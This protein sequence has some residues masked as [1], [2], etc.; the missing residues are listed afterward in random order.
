[1]RWRRP[2]ARTCWRQSADPPSTDARQEIARDAQGPISSGFHPDPTICRVVED[3][4]LANSS[5]DYVP[6][7]PLGRSRDVIPKPSAGVYAAIAQ[8][9]A[10]P[11]RH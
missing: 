2:T 9:N 8:R 5:F 3:Y 7:A 6:G 4:F 10:V 1:M 11:G